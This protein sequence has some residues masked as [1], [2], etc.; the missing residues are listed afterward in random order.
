MCICV[1]VL[2]NRLVTMSLRLQNHVVTP[3]PS[4]VGDGTAAM[5]AGSPS[6]PS[7]NGYLNGHGESLITRSLLQVAHMSVARCAMGAVVV[8]KQLVVL[9]K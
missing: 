3:S 6:P 1:A 7:G 8:G 9:G 2:D 4:D 5:D